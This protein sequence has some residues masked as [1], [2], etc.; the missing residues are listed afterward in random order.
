MTL[1]PAQRKQLCP[2]C[3]TDPKAARGRYCPRFA[4]L[5][6]HQ[7][8]PAFESYIPRRPP[9]P[10]PDNVIHLTSY[11]DKHPPSAWDQRDE[12]TWIDNL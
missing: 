4:C 12:P 5:C 10:L 1:T 3:A 2:E 9:E 11:R 7:S 8:C 6:G